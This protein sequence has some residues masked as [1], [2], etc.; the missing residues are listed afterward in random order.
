MSSSNDETSLLEKIEVQRRRYMR[1]KIILDAL[2]NLPLNAELHGKVTD[3]ILFQ[4]LKDSLP[5]SETSPDIRLLGL[6]LEDMK[7][8][9]LSY[10]EQCDVKNALEKYL[11]KNYHRF[12]DD[13]E[14]LLQDKIHNEFHNQYTKDL[15]EKLNKKEQEGVD[16]IARIGISLD[17]TVKL[18]TEK[19]PKV[20][21]LKLE[22]YDLKMKILHTKYKILDCK[23]KV[24]TFK[25]I[26]KCIEAY[27]E[28][29]NDVHKQ[30]EES[31]RNIQTLALMKEK[32]NMVHCKE[33][34]SILHSYLQYKISVQEKKELLNFL[35]KSS[36]CSGGS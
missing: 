12:S 36:S 2:A 26:D 29:L 33:F 22:E 27:Q 23:T 1:N 30:K 7:Q 34:D 17:E 6:S 14:D 24:S 19:L 8:P 18:R 4:D 15:K 16:I 21:D 11:T 10:V 20:I 13:F 25:E 28:L 35:Q 9:K 32:Y 5:L 3:I 31:K